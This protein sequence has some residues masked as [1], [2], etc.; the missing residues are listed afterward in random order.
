MTSLDPKGTG[1][2]RWSARWKR[3]LNAFAITFDG[4]LSATRH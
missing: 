3:A 1:R 4:R 2:K